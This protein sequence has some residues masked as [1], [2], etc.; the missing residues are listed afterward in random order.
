MILSNLVRQAIA[1][2]VSAIAKFEVPANKWK[3]LLDFLYSC[4]NH[5]NP[6]YREVGLYLLSTLI[7]PIAEQLR[8]HFPHLFG[9]FGQ[10]L[11]DPQSVTVRVTACQ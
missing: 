2:V 6:A 7:E 10:A 8:P 9:L 3:E 4:C 5:Q 11:K 1:G